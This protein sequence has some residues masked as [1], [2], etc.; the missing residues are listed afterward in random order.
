MWLRTIGLM[1]TLVLGLLA[2]PL[3]ADAQQA[4]KMYRIGFLSQH[5]GPSA[6][7]EAFL[8]GLHDLGWIEGKN[9]TI[10]YRWAAGESQIVSLWHTWT[11][12]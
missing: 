9:I 10:E 7:Y 2:V 12:F 8:Q 11:R 4:E 1:V 3:L 6:G 5:A